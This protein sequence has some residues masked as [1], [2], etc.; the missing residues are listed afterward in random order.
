MWYYRIIIRFIGSNPHIVSHG[1]EEGVMVFPWWYLVRKEEGQGLT[2]YGLTL[3]LIAIAAV[4][5]LTLIGMALFHPESSGGHGGLWG[6]AYDWL[7]CA[8]TK[9]CAALTPVPPP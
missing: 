4:A 2:E 9:D 8:F 1:D 3:V 6:Y 5:A 7:N